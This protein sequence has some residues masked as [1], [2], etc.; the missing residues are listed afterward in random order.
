MDLNTDINKPIDILI[1]TPYEFVLSHNTISAPVSW[2]L[3]LDAEGGVVLIHDVV[4][5]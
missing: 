4:D 3:P 2:H 1:N 5:T